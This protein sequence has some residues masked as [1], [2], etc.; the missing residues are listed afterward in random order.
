MNLFEQDFVMT[1]ASMSGYKELDGC[2]QHA[3]RSLCFS[4]W[5]KGVQRAQMSY[6]E[7]GLLRLAETLMDETRILVDAQKALTEAIEEAAQQ[8]Q[9]Q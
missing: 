9:K 5:V 3:L 4:L 1:T 2:A 8:E 7:G 6:C